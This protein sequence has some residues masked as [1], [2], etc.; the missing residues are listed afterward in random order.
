MKQIIARVA[1]VVPDYDLAIAFY[2]NLLGFDL[3]E[4][5][6]VGDG[7]RWVLVR[8]K[9]ATETALLI[10]K[11]DGAR[12][13]AAIGNQAGGRVGFFLFTDDFDRDHS[14]MLKAGVRFVEAPRREV[15]GTVA[16]FVDPFGNQWDLLQP[17]T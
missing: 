15:Y 9:G 7:K 12:Q 6:D 11:A 3:L 2:C 1:L 10:A 14:A 16:V 17:A 5:A 4:D 8:P 13:E